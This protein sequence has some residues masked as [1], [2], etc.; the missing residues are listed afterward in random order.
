MKNTK[1]VTIALTGGLGNQLFQLAAALSVADGGIVELMTKP[2]YPRKNSKGEPEI[3]SFTLPKNVVKDDSGIFIPLLSKM[4]GFNLRSG[5]KPRKIEII[6]RPIIYQISRVILL[7]L[8]GKFR[9]V[10]TGRDLG[11]TPNLATGKKIF[12]IG[13]FQTYKYISE[14]NKNNFIK[15]LEISSSK[16]I[17]YEKIAA[18]EHPL[19]VHVRRGDYRLEKSFGILDSSYYHENCLNLWNTKK[20]NK[21]WLFSDELSEAIEMIP[22][23]LVRDLRVINTTEFSSAETLQLM[24]LGEGYIIAN[25]TFSWWGAFLSQTHQPVVVAPEP[26]FMLGSNPINLIPSGWHLAHRDA[27]LK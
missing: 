14:I 9:R 20:Y 13:Y 27:Y 7:V 6:L 10:V 22:R 2:G 4:F 18:L 21:I 3:F 25:S 8:T 5:F 16:L 26:W 1:V 11:F 23:E 12:L 15:K 24:R 19:V 17:R